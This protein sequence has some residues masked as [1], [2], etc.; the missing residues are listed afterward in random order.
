MAAKDRIV[1]I[2]GVYFDES[3]IEE[4]REEVREEIR[5]DIVK[6]ALLAK[7][8]KRA[9]SPVLRFAFT[10]LQ[11]NGHMGPGGLKT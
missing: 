2:G 5:E 3:F 4:V 9:I 11:E 1:N 6:Q 8:D 10:V 7:L